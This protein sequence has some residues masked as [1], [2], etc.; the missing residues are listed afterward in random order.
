[1]K[2]MMQWLR[3]LGRWW[4]EAWPAWGAFAVIGAVG[5]VAMFLPGSADDRVR[6]TGIFLEIFG[7]LTVAVGLRDKRRVFQR[8]SLIEMLQNWMQRF[9]RWTAESRTIGL[10]GVASS[11][12]MGSGYAYGWHGLPPEPKVE[13]HLNALEKNV[14]TVKRLAL[15]AQAQVQTEATKWGKEIEAES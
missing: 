5:L 11:E 12:S 13:D 7:I 4:W 14:E 6:Y 2:R 3:A 8:P 10:T 9:P 1:M 15:D